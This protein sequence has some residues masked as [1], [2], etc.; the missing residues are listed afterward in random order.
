MTRTEYN[1]RRAA[2]RAAAYAAHSRVRAQAEAATPS[3][4][5]LQEAHDAAVRAPLPGWESAAVRR[6]VIIPDRLRGPRPGRVVLVGI[7]PIAGGPGDD[8]DLLLTAQPKGSSINIGTLS[9]SRGDTDD[10]HRTQPLRPM[11]GKALF[12]L[13]HAPTRLSATQ[14]R[15]LQGEPRNSATDPSTTSGGR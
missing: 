12:R 1:K 9:D 4:F 5:K 6:D 15:L 14:R 11:H 10:R 7:D 2:K 8:A 13:I 3:G